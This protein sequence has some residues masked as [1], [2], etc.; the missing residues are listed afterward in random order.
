MV[1][2]NNN[3][4]QK[5]KTL[6]R[7]RNYISVIKLFGLKKKL[8]DSLTYALLIKEK[9]TKLWVFYIYIYIQAALG[10]THNH[11]IP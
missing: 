11:F 3:N 2:M 10:G 7:S 5:K 1:K 9:N 8:I 4:K 6:K